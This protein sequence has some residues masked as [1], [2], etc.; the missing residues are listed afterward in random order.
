[1]MSL[2]SLKPELS[3]ALKVDGC[4]GCPKMDRNLKHGKVFLTFVSP[5]PWMFT[6]ENRKIQLGQFVIPRLMVQSKLFGA[7]VVGRVLPIILFYMSRIWDIAKVN[8]RV[9]RLWS[10]KLME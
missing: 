6:S 5:H 8:L 10:I 9:T 2:I 7:V 1:M 3:S 4:I